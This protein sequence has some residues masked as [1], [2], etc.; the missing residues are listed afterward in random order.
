MSKQDNNPVAIQLAAT[1]GGS[2]PVTK[3]N[4]GYV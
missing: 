1:G 3:H 2:F 4:W